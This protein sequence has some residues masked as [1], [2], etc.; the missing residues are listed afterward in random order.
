MMIQRLSGL[1]GDQFSGI[2]S[3][4]V[5]EFKRSHEKM[6]GQHDF[7]G[8]ARYG[9]M[10]H[11]GEPAGRHAQKRGTSGHFLTKGYCPLS[12]GYKLFPRKRYETPLNDL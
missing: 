3:F 7:C 10:H 9:F 6:D 4:P 1:G 8:P 12:G 5:S 11:I 2:Y